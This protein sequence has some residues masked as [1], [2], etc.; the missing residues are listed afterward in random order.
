MRKKFLR[1]AVVLVVLAVCSGDAGAQYV[2]PP[3]LG[4]LF[5]PL[6]GSLALIAQG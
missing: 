1:F 6:D 4:P 5:C 3:T 2:Q